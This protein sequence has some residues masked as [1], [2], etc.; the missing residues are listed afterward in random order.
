MVMI[1]ERVR[2]ASRRRGAVGWWWIALSA[3]AIAVLAPLPYL[4]DSLRGLAEGHDQIAANYVPRPSWAQV[5][6]YVHIGCGGLALLLSPAQ[7]AAR[8]RARAPR[9]H[10]VCGRV[11]MGCMVLAG[12]AGLVL[13]PMNLAG[14]VGTAGFGTLG[15]LWIGFAVA[16]YRAIRRGDVASHRRWAVRAFALTYAAVMLRLWLVLLVPLHEVVAGLDEDA[17]F[18]RAY[19]IVPFLCWVPNLLVAEVMLRRRRSGR[20]TH[21]AGGHGRP[22]VT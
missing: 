12:S 6:F 5:A 21:G 15:A 19:L 22:P 18:D 2:R 13:A 1:D 16:A 10:R 8:L 11:A 17:A 7:F 4:T 14:A 20:E 9:V 3:V